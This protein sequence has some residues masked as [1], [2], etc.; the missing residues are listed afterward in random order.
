MSK[1]KR[2]G[3]RPPLSER[4]SL[5][6]LE[7]EYAKLRAA[8]Y[9]ISQISEAVSMRSS[10]MRKRERQFPLL[11]VEIQKLRDEKFAANADEL[12][13]TRH[14]VLDD[15][16]KEL[17]RMLV[18]G[19]LT[20]SELQRAYELQASVATDIETLEAKFAPPEVGQAEEPQ[21]TMTD[22]LT[23]TLMKDKTMT[24]GEILRKIRCYPDE[25]SCPSRY[26]ELW[27]RIHELRDDCPHCGRRGDE[28]YDSR[29]RELF[30]CS[31]RI[32]RSDSKK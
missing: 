4:H 31:I 1:K 21:L 28:G 26:R 2:T 29:L 9:T 18:A 5:T 6:D 19:N 10:E 8:G 11:A 12:S 30:D 16:R 13:A 27:R 14:K 20:I 22:L 7:L 24:K 3:G 32:S 15:L 17:S 25:Q 23:I